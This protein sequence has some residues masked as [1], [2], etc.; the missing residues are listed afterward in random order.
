MINIKNK[1]LIVILLTFVLITTVFTGCIEKKKE[2]NKEDSKENQEVSKL[3][4]L[5]VEDG[6]GNKVKFEKEPMKIISLAPSHTEILYSLGVGSKVIGN[7]TYCDYP[8]EAKKVTKIGDAQNVNLEKIIELSPD[9]VIQYGEGKK[10]VNKGIK[11]AG[12]KL[13]SYEPESIDEV[14]NVIKEL[15]DVTNS[16]R[17]AKI[18]TVELGAKKDYIIGKVKDEKQVKVFYEIWHEPLRAAGPGSFVDELITLAGGENIAKDAKGKYPKFDFEQL[19]E[20]NPEIY[21]TANDLKSKTAESIKSR[22]GYEAIKAVKDDKVYLLDGNMLSRPG[23]RIV[24][25][26][27]LV[28]R[29]LHPEAFKK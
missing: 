19:I 6:F 29:K 13:L 24:D 9:L 4:P 26:L 21:L 3:Y 15:G 22:E 10:E 17:K 1:K 18:L 2:N 8:K 14:L 28:A 11:A 25:A 12:I 5:T 23:P 20:R 16:R 27:E 7:T